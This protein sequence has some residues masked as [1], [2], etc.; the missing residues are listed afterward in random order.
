[1]FPADFTAFVVFYNV[2]AGKIS[3]AHPCLEIICLTKLLKAQNWLVNYSIFRVKSSILES[4]VCF[5][6]KNTIYRIMLDANLLDPLNPQTGKY[7]SR[8]HASK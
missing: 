2:H 4:V 1:M 5:G 3:I 6:L 8:L 7:H